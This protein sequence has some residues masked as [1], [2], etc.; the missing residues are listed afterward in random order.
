MNNLF[1]HI[2]LLLLNQTWPEFL[3]DVS[4]GPQNYIVWL[5]IFFIVLFLLSRLRNILEERSVTQA[6]SI[7]RGLV[8]SFIAF[9]VTPIVFFIF[10]NVIALVHGVTMINVNFLIDWIGLTLSSYWWLL[11]CFFGSESISNAKEMYSLHAI[12]RILWIILPLTFVWIRMTKSRIGKLLILPVIVGVF[13]ITRYKKAPVTFLTEDPEIVRRISFLKMFVPD[14]SGASTDNITFSLEQRKMVAIGLLSLVVIGF[15]VGMY[16]RRRVIGL[17]ISTLGLLGFIL[18]APHEQEKVIPETHKEH[19]NANLDSLI[20]QMVVLHQQN[21]DTLE[22]YRLSLK[23]QSA[24][25]ARIE[26]GDNIIFPDSLC[27]E[28]KSYFYDWC[29]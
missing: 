1:C 12:I 28:Y 16:L 25:H 24:Y 20:H 15:I 18:M 27:K 9:I 11:K 17:I 22:I 21:P 3:R 26:M 19:Y 4:R 29:K 13:V 6:I 23:I 7:S 14:P 5:I 10:I 8:G 2:N